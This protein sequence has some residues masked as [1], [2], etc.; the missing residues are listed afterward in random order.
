VVC[1]DG[2]HIAEK[3]TADLA[4]GFESGHHPTAENSLLTKHVVAIG[5]SAQDAGSTPA[6]STISTSTFATPYEVADISQFVFNQL[7]ATLETLVHL[8]PPVLF[9]YRIICIE[10][11][12]AWVERL[13]LTALPSDWQTEPPPR[14]TRQLGDGWARSLRS[15]ILAVPSVIIP[16]EM[17]FVLNPAHSDFK[18]I[19]VSKPAP[20]TFD[21]RL[22]T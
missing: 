11:D 14:S 21:P 18:Q 19:T 6:A 9:N 15:A 8:N 4:V 12:E 7:L 13:P 20:F 5:N 2:A 3:L 22:L 1:G 17:N 10:F 16:D